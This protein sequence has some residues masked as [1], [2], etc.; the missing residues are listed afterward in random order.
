MPINVPIQPVACHK[1]LLI[2]ARARIADKLRGMVADDASRILLIQPLQVAE[3]KIDTLIAKRQ[4]YYNYPP[5]GLGILADILGRKGFDSHIVDLNNLVFTEVHGGLSGDSR[6]IEQCWKQHLGRALM[7]FRPDVVA[8]TC[9]FTMTHP[10]LLKIAEHVKAF[11][12]ALPVFAGGV[13]VTNSA[14]M[15][16]RDSGAIDFIGL[17]EGDQS[18]SSALD[19]ARGKL[20]ISHLSQICTLIDGDFTVINQGVPLP[21]EGLDTVPDYQLLPIGQYSNLGEIGTFRFWRPGISRSAPVLSTRGCRARCSFCSV[22]NFNGAS[23]RTRSVKS[24]IE[25]ITELHEAYGIDHITWLDDDLFFDVR[26]T[27]A[28]FEAIAKLPFRITWDASNGIIASAAAAHPELITAAAQSGCIGMYFGIESGDAKILRAVKK[29]SGLKHYLKVGELMAAYPEIFTRGF[30]IV[31][32]PNETV[33][34]IRHTVELAKHMNL[35]WY[36]VQLLTPLPN[37]EIHQEM[38]DLGLIAENDLDTEGDGFTM[39]SVREGERQRRREIQLKDKAVPF[40]DLST[41]PAYH[42]PS[43]TELNDIWLSADFAINYGRIE[44]MEDR[45]K[46]RKIAHFLTDI[47]DRMTLD[48]PLANH[49][50]ARIHS[51]L[52]T[53]SKAKNRAQRVT[54]V[55]KNSNYWRDRFSRLGLSVEAN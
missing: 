1:P 38:V 3:A 43:K 33:G 32:F 39:F 23:V 10:V 37:T 22:R 51:R 12:A 52:D 18:F 53:M 6:T 20:D 34:Q 28:L 54:H 49:F 26:R 27:I 13:H 40:F 5:Y 31:G 7:K 9:M 55:L 36:T 17:Y 29:P 50:L 44:T 8:V 42:I 25:E 21:P 16:L 30:L 19:V 15:I 24:V 2:D 47:A 46:L 11:D 14:E 48:H 4:R 35:D 41:Q 45:Q